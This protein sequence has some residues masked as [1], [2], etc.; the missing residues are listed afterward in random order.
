[1]CLRFI[2]GASGANKVSVH[3]WHPRHILDLISALPLL[4][5]SILWFL[6]AY[7]QSLAW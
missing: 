7:N 4:G 1:M 3:N 6:S 2:S 5:L